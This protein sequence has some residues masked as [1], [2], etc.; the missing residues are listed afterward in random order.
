METEKSQ[1]TE[2]RPLTVWK[3]GAIRYNA[4]ATLIA[5]IIAALCGSACNHKPATPVST[6]IVRCSFTSSPSTLN[7]I[8]TQELYSYYV[9][10]Q[11][12]NGLTD[13]TPKGDLFPGLAEKWEIKDDGK[14]CHFTLR[15]GVRFQS[16]RALTALD[17]KKTFE[18]ILDPK[19]RGGAGSQ[20]LANIHGAADFQ[21]G[22]TTQLKGII[23]LSDYDF[24]IVQ[25]QPDVYFPY[26]CSV[27]CLYIVDMN[28]LQGQDDNWWQRFSAGTGPFRLKS[29]QRDQRI[30][31]SANPEYW[32]GKPQLDG[33]EIQVVPSEDTA[34]SMY[35]DGQLD[36]VDAPNAQLARIRAT[37]DLSNQLSNTPIARLVYIGFNEHLYAPFAD[38]RVRHAINLVIDRKR[39]ASNI[40]EETAYPLFGV[41]PVGFKGYD[42]SI[43]EIPY[44]PDEARRLLAEAGYSKS[45]PLPAITFSC[46]PDSL[47]S[48]VASYIASQLT[49]E[50]GMNVK[51]HQAERSKILDDLRYHR[52]PFFISGSTAAFG[53][54]RTILF[55]VFGPEGFARYE[56][57]DFNAL[58]QKAA[59]TIDPK[60]RDIIYRKAEQVLMSNW[61]VAP[62]Y[63]KKDFLLI[64]PYVK[65]VPLSSLGW[66]T[67]EPVKI[68]R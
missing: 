22:K 49:R 48:M 33:L 15:K 60:Q 31:F 30:V 14:R 23:V 32:R 9:V 28:A 43:A 52:V 68:I 57:T 35:E 62:L 6:R 2:V 18:A 47:E 42:K 4:I 10:R 66:D 17:V 51:L 58:M 1:Q 26:Y 46:Y 7:P 54:V 27:E 21:S 19:N 67:F 65:D 39:M 44:N 59:Q 55:S 38:R 50:L 24:E 41:I 37:P 12:Y 34:L 40:M 63:T 64:K 61:A 25:D 36:M 16:G 3:H 5:T 13:R 8:T 29:Y 20:Y 53:D 56:N 45:N 11:M